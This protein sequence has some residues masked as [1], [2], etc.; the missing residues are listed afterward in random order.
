MELVTFNLEIRFGNA[1]LSTR[2]DDIKY[3]PGHLYRST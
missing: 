2:A 3:T 1:L